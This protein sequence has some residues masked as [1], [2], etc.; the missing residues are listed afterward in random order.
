VERVRPRGGGRFSRSSSSYSYRRRRT[1][2][3]TLILTVGVGGLLAALTAGV[4]GST[5]DVIHQGRALPATHFEA[6][7]LGGL[8]EDEARG[9]LETHL[10]AFRASPAVFFSGTSEWRPSASEIG[11][12]LDEPEMG[13][14]AVRA[15]RPEPLPLRPF[16]V[17][18]SLLRKPAVPLAVTLDQGQLLAFVHAVAAE[19]DRDPT[20]AGLSIRNGQ[21]VMGQSAPGR[22]VN[23]LE[24]A[25][26]VELPATLVPQRIEVVVET[27]QPTVSD[28]AVQDAQAAATRILSS[29]LSLHLDDKVWSLTPAQLGPMVEFKRIGAA[30][31][32]KLSATL[33]EAR[34][35]AYVKT[36]A[37]DIDK[38]ATSAQLRWNGSGASVVRE[39]TDGV[40]LDQAAAVKSI[41]MHAP[42]DARDVLLTATVT[43]P[44]VTSDPKTVGAIK[45]LVAT[46]TSKFAGSAPERVNNIQV[47][48]SKLD[49]VVIPPGS[50]FS[51]LTA[52]GPITKENG[53]QEGLTIQGDETVPGIG[54]GV[55]QVSTTVFR[56]AF[57]GGLPIVER[58]QHTYRVGYYEQDGSPVGFDAAVYDPG[59]DLRFKNDTEYAILVQAAVDT[60]ASTL[61]FRLYSTTVGRE[62]K[63]TPS[64]ANEVKA[65]PK[66]PDVLDATLPK[67]TRKQVE[68]TAD[69]VDATIRRAVTVG[70]KALVNDSFFS[71]YV[72]WREKW[73]VGP[74]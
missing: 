69:G 71:R 8:T 33:N 54:G 45:E 29:P 34:V 5:I 53:Y 14:G 36:L 67:G 24:T 26:R 20:N 4:A 11:I 64:K 13:R 35:A 12:K 37:A 22:K 73:A 43:K 58:H 30:G 10:N 28:I 44:A 61:S 48:A 38:P 57:F 62:V 74:S 66:L 70:G 31:S 68:W 15:G 39:S 41:V 50:T 56:A 16:G 1:G 23:I 40:K 47:A 72:P 27:A 7:P 32:E 18:F 19:V 46:G 65:G 51:F 3:E 6:L 21:V 42:T 9:M 17:L 49:G 60:K 52:L 2:L 55:C 25:K 59:V 63:L